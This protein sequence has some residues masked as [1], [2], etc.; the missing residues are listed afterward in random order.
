[1][2]TLRGMLKMANEGAVAKA[3]EATCNAY[4]IVVCSAIAFRLGYQ[5]C[6]YSLP[7]V[8]SCHNYNGHNRGNNILTRILT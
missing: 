1:M 2:P 5:S 6:S 8:S 3:S 4:C 7:H